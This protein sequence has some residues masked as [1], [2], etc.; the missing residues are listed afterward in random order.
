MIQ[1]KLRKN[2]TSATKCKCLISLFIKDAKSKQQVMYIYNQPTWHA[3]RKK[4]VRDDGT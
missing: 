2:V 3:L 4:T 1:I